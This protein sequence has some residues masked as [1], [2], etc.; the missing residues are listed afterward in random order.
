MTYADRIIR[1]YSGE[2]QK[3]QRV[4]LKTPT[5]FG[6]MIM[7]EIRLYSLFRE[8]EMEET[9]LLLKMP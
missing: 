5:D 6:S 3:P 9:I 2:I 4:E 1:E 7:D 8:R